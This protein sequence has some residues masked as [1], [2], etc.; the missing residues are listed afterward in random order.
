[1]QNGERNP[2][3]SCQMVHGTNDITE[4]QV[5]VERQVIVLLKQIQVKL[6]RDCCDISIAIL[7]VTSFHYVS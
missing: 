5:T 2:G 4:T 7:K 1:M 3:E 6:L